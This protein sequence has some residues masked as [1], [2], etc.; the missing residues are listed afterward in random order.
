MFY[1]IISVLA[2]IA[3]AIG[4]ARGNCR[5]DPKTLKI[6]R[7]YTERQMTMFTILLLMLACGATF[8]F[9]ATN[10]DAL[11]AIEQRFAPTYWHQGDLEAAVLIELMLIACF[12]W[13][14]LVI[15]MQAAECIFAAKH[16]K[17]R[18]MLV[19]QALIRGAMEQN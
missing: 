14:G 6:H 17:T 13:L 8:V 11:V 18:R 2:A 5:L 1:F 9:G 4:L 16:R 15:T 12:V 3:I 19:R 10:F 7:H